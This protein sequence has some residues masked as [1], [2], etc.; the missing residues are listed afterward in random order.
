MLQCDDGGITEDQMKATIGTTHHE[1]CGATAAWCLPDDAPIH[2]GISAYKNYMP[3]MNVY[4]GTNR[5]VSASDN[6]IPQ[7]GDILYRVD[8]YVDPNDGHVTTVIGVI[9]DTVYTIEGN[10]RDKVRLMGRTFEELAA[11]DWHYTRHILFTFNQPDISGLV[12]EWYG[13]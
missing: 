4:Y 2:A 8:P 7:C 6:Y 1:W 3:D 13:I 12:D 10:S 5:Y 9:G 11:G